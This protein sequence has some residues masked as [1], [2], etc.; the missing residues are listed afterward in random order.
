MKFHT[1]FFKPVITESNKPVFMGY[2]N[3]FY[4][5]FHNIIQ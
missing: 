2:N 1:K 3:C 5:L 4:L